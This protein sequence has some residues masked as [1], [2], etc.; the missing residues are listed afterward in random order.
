VLIDASLVRMCLVPAVMSLLGSHAWWMPRWMEPI[1]PQ[2][3]L[4]GS[5]A[6]E[7]AAEP[8]PATA[9]PE[10]APAAAVPERT[11]A[12]A[13]PGPASAGD[14]TPSPTPT[15]SARP[16][17]PAPDGPAGPDGAEDGGSVPVAVVHTRVEADLIAGLLGSNGVRAIVSADDAGGQDPQL[18]Q[19][20]GVRVLVAH[21]DETL[22]R[23]VLAETG[24]ADV[25]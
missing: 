21:S 23:Q 20:Q 13:T 25:S 11:S 17:G 3:Q 5:A 10:P 1:V 12:A 6:T 24:P 2:L 8:V 9:V 7:A 14:D 19:V 18:Q 22:A 4:E 15:E 16:S